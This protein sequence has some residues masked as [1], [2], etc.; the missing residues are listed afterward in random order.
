MKSAVAAGLSTKQKSGAGGGCSPRGCETP[1][2]VSHHH[3]SSLP[4][5]TDASSFLLGNLGIW[6][7]TV[8]INQNGEKNC[9]RK[10]NMSSA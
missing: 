10:S 8:R 2:T 4:P 7:V 1:T 9:L 5:H 6:K 3:H